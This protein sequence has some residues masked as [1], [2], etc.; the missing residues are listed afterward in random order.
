MSGRRPRAAPP[1]AEQLVLGKGN[2]P[3]ST[4]GPPPMMSV[5]D[6]AEYLDLSERH[7][8]RE[9]RGKRLAAHH[10][11]RLVRVAWEDLQIYIAARRRGPR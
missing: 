7:I 11:G 6:V 9:I 10:F 2:V 3:G 8:A 4:S 5:R 1:K